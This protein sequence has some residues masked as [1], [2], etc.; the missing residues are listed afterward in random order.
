MFNDFE[1]LNGTWGYKSI[2]YDNTL[3]W[4]YQHHII[5][6][7]TGLFT[8]RNIEDFKTVW[9]IE[10]RTDLTYNRFISRKSSN[11]YLCKSIIE[12]LES[13]RE[14]GELRGKCIEVINSYELT[15]EYLDVLIG[16]AELFNKYLDDLPSKPKCI[17]YMISLFNKIAT[18]LIHQEVSSEIPII[19]ADDYQNFYD[20]YCHKYGYDNHGFSEPSLELCYMCVNGKKST[21]LIIR[22]LQKTI[23]FHMGLLGIELQKCYEYT[24]TKQLTFDNIDMGTVFSLLPITHNLYEEDCKLER[25]SD[26]ERYVK[27]LMG[28]C[29]LLRGACE[30]IDSFKKSK[31]YKN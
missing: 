11:D 12:M 2:D 9:D 24:I 8:V 16:S 6:R 25:G 19:F 20:D 7:T 22:M 3:P 28:V 29:E 31:Y 23:S 4:K 26:R 18:R 10:K 15:C 30:G 27:Y 17:E 14:R 5:K 21:E 1:A 13:R